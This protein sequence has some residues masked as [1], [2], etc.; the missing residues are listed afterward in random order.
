V[1]PSKLTYLELEKETLGTEFNLPVSEQ[2]NT[3][4]NLRTCLN[5][6]LEINGLSRESHV[7]SEFL[8]NY[9]DQMAYFLKTY[10]KSEKSIPS[11]KWQLNKFNRTFILHSPLKEM[12]QYT[13]QG[14]LEE[15]LVRK[16][17]TVV[18]LAKITGI[19]HTTI[20]NWTS[21]VIPSKQKKT[22]DYLKR[23]SIALGLPREFLQEH[24]LPKFHF[25]TVK[26]YKTIDTEF[27][28]KQRNVI[29]KEYRIK[30]GQWDDAALSNVTRFLKEFRDH[31]ESGVHQRG[32]R[33]YSLGKIDGWTRKGS[34]TK[35]FGECASFFGYLLN[36]K[37]EPVTIL[38]IFDI[39]KMETFFVFFKERQSGKV[40]TTLSSF[41]HYVV[42]QAGKYFLNN[43][44]RL[45][46]YVT[47]SD[48]D[49]AEDLQ[50]TSVADLETRKAFIAKERLEYQLADI[51]DLML[52]YSEDMVISRDPEERIRDW[53]DEEN[54]LSPVIGAVEY[55]KKDFMKYDAPKGRSRD[56]A[57][58]ILRDLVMIS[59]LIEK[60]LRNG[61]CVQLEFEK[62]V[63]KYNEGWDLDVP[64]RLVKNKKALTR[65]FSPELCKWLEIYHQRH[66]EIN[67]GK[68]L[69][70][71]G[72]SEKVHSMY[73]A[74]SNRIHKYTNRKIGPH[75][76]RHLRATYYILN[77]ENGL[78]MAAEVLNASV[79]TVEKNYAHLTSRANDLKDNIALERI[80]SRFR[81]ETADELEIKVMVGG[82]VFAISSWR[83]EVVKL[84]VESPK[85]FKNKIKEIVN[86]Q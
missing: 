75:S 29:A 40:T 51:E 81:D 83:Q 86:E 20:R 19:H 21:G 73:E 30:P 79:R 36:V 12:G 69:F 82:N 62:H 78:I 59:I 33:K 53:L 25:E 37:K 63:K 31:K 18:G 28:K 52:D 27:S 6:W 60:P 23:I 47:I 14:F 38:D 5:N 48:E 65:E 3:T 66:N 61:T 35:F 84:L 39:Q 68:L 74:L 70:K 11:L 64:P 17:L 85:G 54:P 44:S 13:F 8:E 58:I 76:F 22:I 15:M 32:K 49:I 80:R 26:K 24:F 2:R 9:Q 72:R 71:T 50:F 10:A 34:S 45:L 43:P 77:F 7:G 57:N 55:M 1:A 4:K 67:D 41:V 16:N 56:I 46:D 42:F